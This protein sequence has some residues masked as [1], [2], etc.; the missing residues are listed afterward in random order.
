LRGSLRGKNG[1]DY[2][3]QS[4]DNAQGKTEGEHDVSAPF[5]EENAQANG[6]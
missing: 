2:Q 5:L 4:K 3:N 1:P 6:N